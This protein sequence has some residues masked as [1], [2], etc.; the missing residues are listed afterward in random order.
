MQ[1]HMPY[2]EASGLRVST[3]ITAPLQAPAPRRIRV[4]MYD[5]WCMTPWYTAAL[6]KSL[7]GLGLDIRLVCPRYHFEPD[8]FQKQ[9]LVTRPG[10]FDLSAQMGLVPTKARQCFRLAE[11]M[12]N[13]ASL[14]AEARSAPPDILHVQQCV[15]LNH[16]SEL[17]LNFLH[18]CRRQGI[19]IIHT[20]HNLLPH[21]QRS[22]HEGLYR[23]LYQLPDA[24][25]CH[26]AE[27]RYALREVFGVKEQC[28][29]MVP[30]GPL[31]AADFEMSQAECRLHLGLTSDRLVFLAQGI[32][33]PYKGMDLLLEAWAKAV[34][35][36]GE[37]RAQLLIAGSGKA[38]DL[39]SLRELTAKLHLGKTVRLDLRYI[40]ADE[41]PV[42]YR[43]ADF[44]V[45]PYR[46][47]TTSGAL[48]TGLNYRKPII[49]SNLLPFG[50]YLT[51]GRNALLFDPGDLD[52]LAIAIAAIAVDENLR[53][54][55]EDESRKNLRLQTQWPEIA[56]RTAEVYRSMVSS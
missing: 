20:V 28:A 9:G 16:G 18:W 4:W 38:S 27:T 56:T 53:R 10:P 6:T 14:M 34:H 26:D 52:T 46:S 29:H 54:H 2:P 25:I 43:S 41:V 21:E 12:A 7:L 13:T 23:K 35:W 19:R 40:P 33:S 15:L 30:H 37:K 42:Y 39:Q 44:L 31:F 45:Y 47:I 32:I 36:M 11:F 50:P 22:S 3:P 8:Y 1:K 24:F 51:S 48:L 49:A 5:P 17:E 55:L